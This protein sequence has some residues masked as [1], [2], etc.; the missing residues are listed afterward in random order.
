MFDLVDSYVRFYGCP[1]FDSRDAAK[2]FR[3]RLFEPLN[4]FICRSGSRFYV[5]RRDRFERMI[6]M[7]VIDSAASD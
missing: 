7:E 2:R 4:W 5:I 6:R 1:S 3:S